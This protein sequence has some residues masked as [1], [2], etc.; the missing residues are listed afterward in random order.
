MYYLK[1]TDAYCNEIYG[2]AITIER[3]IQNPSGGG[4]KIFDSKSR[5]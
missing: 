1:G 4:Y 2:D 5:L 3:R